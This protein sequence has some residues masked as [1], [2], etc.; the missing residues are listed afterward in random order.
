MSDPTQVADP[1]ATRGRRGGLR[2]VSRPIAG[3]DGNPNANWQRLS[4]E[5]L[6][7]LPVQVASPNDPCNLPGGWTAMPA[8]RNAGYDEVAP[9]RLSAVAGCDGLPNP[10]VYEP[11]A[12]A[13]LDAN[14][15]RE[16]EV[17]L[18]ARLAALAS[19]GT[20]VAGDPADLPG[21]LAI[22]PLLGIGVAV[23]AI[24]GTTGFG[25]ELTVI[26]PE[27]TQPKL[28]ATQAFTRVG[29][30]WRLGDHG[31]LWGSGTSGA[32]PTGAPSPGA[33][34]FWVWVVA[35]LE[36]ALHP[37]VRVVQEGVPHLNLDSF[38]AQRL[39]FVDFEPA[40]ARAVLVHT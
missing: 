25:G 37:D 17:E 30:A 14:T 11:R 36:H 28:L 3:V 24:R 7:G 9:F 1:L 33:M 19:A 38:R 15:D 34:E 40:A 4:R 22:D 32:G 35:G 26:M 16:M 23:N 8:V 18:S 20:A 39:A 21:A 27:W 10:A 5:R 13:L 6:L 29:D 2:S 31:V 12:R